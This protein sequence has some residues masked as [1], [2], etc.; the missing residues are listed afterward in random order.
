MRKLFMLTIVAVMITVSLNVK[1]AVA[2]AA[3]PFPVERP[4]QYV[5]YHDMRTGIYGS[6]EPLDRLMGILKIADKKYLI[7]I[8]YPATGK[9]F[10]YS[11][12]YVLNK[13]IMEFTP[14]NIQG[15][16]KEGT[17]IM[18]DLLNVLNY[19]GGETLKHAGRFKNKEDFS[20]NSS[21]PN[22]DRKFVNS[23]KWWAPFYK[24]TS[25]SNAETDKWASKG[26]IALKLVCFGSVYDA[27]AET[28]TLISKVP[29]YYNEKSD[30]KKYVIPETEKVQ[31]KLA[32]IAF[33]L[34]KNWIYEKPNPEYGIMHETYWLK[35]FSVRD[36]QI[37]IETIN[38]SDMHMEKNEI[39]SFTATLQYQTCV[40]TDTVSIDH[41]RK[42]LT[43]CL[44]DP[45]S[46]SSTL[47]KY[48]SL[49]IKN[50]ILTL[51]NFSAFD[52]IYYANMEYFDAIINTGIK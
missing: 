36:A 18:A 23:Y 12:R 35:K 34:D 9:T 11:G 21:W 5:Y 24:L 8:Y 10:Y 44:W 13:G 1:D 4:G 38:I 19:L 51:L 42:I 27:D 32:G 48:R 52:F 2:V 46:G 49:G 31:V 28:F 17:M 14:E 37:G 43:L 7:R 26:G 3:D 20:V 15:D 33:T 29:V 16:A 47:T 6:N 39:D 25:S 41:G 45:K 22:Y 40:I 50:K 30:L